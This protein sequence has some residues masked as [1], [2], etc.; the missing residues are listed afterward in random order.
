MLKK[1]FKRKDVERIRNIVKGKS[2]ESA[3]NQIGY[4]AKS[5]ERVEG[6]VWVEN[7]KTWTIKD[8]LKQT[9]TKLD[10]IK[11][12]VLTPLFCPSCGNVMKKKLDNKMYKIHK[13]CFDCV[14]DMEHHLKL[15]G[16]YEEYENKLIA[17]NAQFYAEELEG[18]LIEAI[19]SSNNHHVSENGE[20]ERWKG[21]VNKEQLLADTKKSLSEYKEHIKEYK[22]N[23]NKKDPNT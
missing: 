3:E 15:E 9:Y 16:K 14:I 13:M 1:E 4:K 8:G 2:F 17:E 18:F 22:D 11:K 10:N 6:D 12:E 5:I 7:N 19:N 21:G 20:V 23:L